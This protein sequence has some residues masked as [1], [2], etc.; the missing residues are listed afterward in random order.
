MRT[1]HRTLGLT[2]PES[3]KYVLITRGVTEDEQTRSPGRVISASCHFRE[4]LLLRGENCGRT[5]GL[6]PT[7][8]TYS[9]QTE[10][11]PAPWMKS[12]TA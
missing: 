5:C 12:R 1:T 7:G 4:K 10:D 9:D 6:L 3:K 11:A 2:C 8:L